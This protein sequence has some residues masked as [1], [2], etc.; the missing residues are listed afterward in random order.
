MRVAL[1]RDFVKKIAVTG[2]QIDYR[3]TRLKGLVLRVTPS[4]VKSWYCEYARG[5]RIWLGRADA[6]GYSEAND[7]AQVIMSDFYRGIDPAEARKPPI[8]VPTLEAFLDG[9]YATWAR[10]NQR[11][12]VQNLARLRTAFKGLL[13]R[14]LD[15]VTALDIERWR[16]GQVDRGLSHETINRDISSIKACLNRAVD[17]E[18]LDRNPLEKVKKARTDDRIKV[19][20]LTEVEENRLRAALDAREER[21]RSERDSANA[22]RKSRKQGLLPDLRDV[23]FTDHLKPLVLLSINTGARRGELFDL[24]WENVDIDRR[25]LT[26]SGAT[27][28][29]K[30]TRHIP[31]NKEATAVLASWHKQTGRREG[32]LFV[33]DDGNRFDRVNTSWRRLLKN[34][35]ITDFRWHDMRHHF[36]SKLVMGGVDLNTVRELLGHSDYSMTLRYA[37]LAPEHKLKAVEVLDR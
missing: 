19:R 25:I 2:K 4:G 22:W 20:Y 6:V 23:L 1:T 34:A 35:A 32:M 24:C 3:D 28:K 16:G 18:V 29:S 27:A 36:A 5:K 9:D 14:K 7:A 33:N 26:V 13:S 21:R 12:H 10:A 15:A 17:W 31:L 37:H 30:R 11:A 8:E